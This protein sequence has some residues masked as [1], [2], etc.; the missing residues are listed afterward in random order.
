MSKKRKAAKNAPDLL[1]EVRA[2]EARIEDYYG[3]YLLAGADPSVIRAGAMIWALGEYVRER[4][5][6]DVFTTMGQPEMQLPGAGLGLVMHIFGDKR[7]RGAKLLITRW[8]TDPAHI[9]DVRQMMA[10]IIPPGGMH[11]T[12]DDGTVTTWRR[13]SFLTGEAE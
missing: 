13:G 8:Q 3:R 11:F 10:A 2:L 4:I 12:E 5:G 6:W 7:L 1:S 9:E